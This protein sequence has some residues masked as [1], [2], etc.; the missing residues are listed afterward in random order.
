MARKLFC[1]I[2]LALFSSSANAFDF[3]GAWATD[4]AKC[5]K[6]FVK[7]H[8][9]IS[10]TPH[11]EFF[12]GGFIVEGARIRGPSA[13][14]KIISRK[15]EGA[16]LHL[17]ASCSTE[18]AVLSPMQLDVRVEDNDKITRFFPNFSEITAPYTRCPL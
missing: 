5:S 4:S 13:A 16:M 18:I 9:K 10:M 14:C 1:A 11:S 3:D 12:G 8:N 7:K 6:I 2:L 17:V 15:E